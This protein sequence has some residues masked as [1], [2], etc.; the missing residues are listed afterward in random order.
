[1]PNEGWTFEELFR[2]LLC[3]TCVGGNIHVCIHVGIHLC[4]QVSAHMCGVQR[5]MSEVFLSPHLLFW[6]Q[7]LS[8]S[9]EIT[10]LTS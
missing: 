5:S 3:L 1:M 10:V 7:G 8:L 9:L 2:V 6:R 4:V